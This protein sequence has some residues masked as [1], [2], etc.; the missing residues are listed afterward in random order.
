M[1]MKFFRLTGD[2]RFLEGIPA[3]LDFLQ[4]IALDPET[5]AKTGLMIG[6]SSNTF[7]PNDALTHAMA[8]TVLYKMAGSPK[9]A[10]KL[11]FKNVLSDMWYSDAVIWAYNNGIIDGYG[12]ESFNANDPVSRQQLVAM[13][14]RYAEYSH[15]DLTV[16]SDMSVF[17]D[18]DIVSDWAKE[19]FEWA[20]S[21]G[22]IN[23]VEPTMLNP[24]GV[25]TRAQCAAILVRFTAN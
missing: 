16:E 21:N 24:R 15:M 14:Y 12:H 22:I 3:A 2:K 5:V 20:I 9:P 6:N 10:Y 7:S 18:I 1:L 25:T 19:P 8:V 4:S 23:G 13:L 11:V 17:T